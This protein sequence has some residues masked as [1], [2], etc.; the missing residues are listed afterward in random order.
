MII[1][2]KLFLI[3]L[4]MGTIGLVIAN[5]LQYVQADYG[6]AVSK[7]AEKAQDVQDN[8]KVP[9][10]IEPSFGIITIHIWAI[11]E[12]MRAYFALLSLLSTFSDNQ[13]IIASTSLLDYPNETFTFTFHYSNIRR[14]SP[15]R[16]PDSPCRRSMCLDSPSLVSNGDPQ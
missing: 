7:L 12:T 2:M 3:V 9:D 15:S 8:P 11:I 13:K 10:S 6:V 1:N 16:I 5:I 14:M 4:I